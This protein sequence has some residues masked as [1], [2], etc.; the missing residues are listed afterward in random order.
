MSDQTHDR[1]TIA[2]AAPRMG[3]AFLSLLLAAAVTGSAASCTQSSD[4]ST[5][6]GPAPTTIGAEN[7]TVV[8]EDT[9]ES[10][11][12]LSGAL[13]AER[14]AT[15]RAE[16]G[17]TVLQTMVE[18][19][20]RVTRGQI[21]ARI[22][23]TTIRDAFLSARSGLTTAE[24]NAR[25]AARELERMERLAEAG[26]IAERDLEQARNA[27]TASESML[28]DAKSRFV[29]AEKMLND[30]RVRAPFAGIVAERQVSA[31]ETVAP[32]GAMFDVIDPSTMRLEASV[33][34]NQLAAL[35]VGAPVT[36][37]VSGYPNRAFTGRI[38]RIS[39]VADPAT[40][41]VGIYASIPNAGQTLVG[42]LFAEGRVASELRVSAVAPAAAIDQRG[43]VPSVVRVKNGQVERVEVELGIRDAATEHHEIVSGVQVGD[44]LLLGP[45]QGLSPG[46]RV[47]FGRTRDTASAQR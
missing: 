42:G 5:G 47:V 30:T 44:T 35:R 4:A 18:A 38:T 31:G 11:P 24:M 27:A 39:P 36:F 32:G 12:L 28:A 33:P 19:G 16:V 1:M 20:E 46:T 21:L 6:D 41:Q 13:A 9:I 29:A 37:T 3:R 14:Q 45:A 23:E 10:G 7:M 26:A 40:R 15:V 2:P 17:G 8:V 43:V 25:T 34:A 22:D